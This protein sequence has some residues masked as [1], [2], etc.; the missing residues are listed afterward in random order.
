[1]YASQM[2]A[3]GSWSDDEQLYLNFINFI[4]HIK[5]REE[6][7]IKVQLDLPSGYQIATA[8]PQT[9]AFVLEATGFQHLVDS[10]SI[11]SPSL[12][13]HQYQMGHCT[14][15]LW[16]Q[17]SIYFDI[18]ELKN[19]FI[20][21]TEKQIAAFGDFPC[22]NYHFLFQLLPYRH[23]HGVEHQYSTVITLGPA[24]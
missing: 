5:G 15:H 1:Y 24:E 16:F 6:E 20:R 13:H 8:L 14:F 12:T 11:A 7:P 3:G 22:S 23:Y 21:F 19:H 18:E 4:F 2:D 9:G 17:G 10:P